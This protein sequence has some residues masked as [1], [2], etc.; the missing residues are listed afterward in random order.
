[1][2]ISTVLSPY[3]LDNAPRLTPPSVFADGGRYKES[4]ERRS[5]KPEHEQ[6]QSAENPV[7]LCLI[8][9]EIILPS[10]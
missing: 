9:P 5:H 3:H 2:I 10:P 8:Q 4:K 1:V 7:D 6:Q